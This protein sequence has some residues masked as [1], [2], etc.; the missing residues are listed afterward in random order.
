MFEAGDVVRF[1]SPTA[2]KEKFHL[3]LGKDDNGPLLAFLF[4][5]S[6][7][8][9]RGDCIMEDGQIPGLPTSPTGL[10]VV[11][12]S[13]VVRMGNRRLETFG[14]VKTGTIDGHAAGEIA[15]FAEKTGVLTSAE[16]KLVVLALK[17]LF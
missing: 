6:K 13:A 11:S 12:F 9:F 15:A 4:L 14:A 8:G 2:G 17:S 5:N 16:K 10:T 1:H 7:P 3:C